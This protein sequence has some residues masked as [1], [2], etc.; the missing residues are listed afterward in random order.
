MRL[1]ERAAELPTSPGVYLFKSER[2]R[3]LYVG[4][5]Q[6]LRARVRQYF[7]ESG[8]DDN[9]GTSSSSNWSF[10]LNA[11]IRSTRCSSSRTFPGQE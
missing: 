1:T 3:V 9:S 4:K 6:N 10:V 7:A 2:G 5:A 11:T 8:G